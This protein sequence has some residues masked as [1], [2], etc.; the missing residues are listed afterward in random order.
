MAIYQAAEQ[1]YGVPWNVLAAINSVETDFGRNLAV[2]SAGAVGWMQFMPATW[3]R[4]GVDGN[5][6]GSKDPRKPEDAIPAAARLPEG[7]GPSHDLHDAI[8]AYNHAESYVQ[9]VLAL[10]RTLRP[11][12]LRHLDG[13]RSHDGPP[14]AVGMPNGGLSAGAARPGDRH[15]GR[16]PR[17]RALGN[18]QSDNAID[19]AVPAGNRGARR[20]RRHRGEYGRLAAVA[21]RRRDRRLQRHA[22]GRQGQ[23]G[24]LHAPDT[25]RSCEPG[26][27]VRAGPGDRLSGYANNVEHLHIGL[28]HGD[29]IA[30]GATGAAC[31]R[32]RSRGGCAAGALAARPS[33]TGP[34]R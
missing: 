7:V 32:Q 14:T 33:S 25:A 2:S 16:P 17:P 28:E 27:R 18:W 11:G 21:R 1:R 26:E 12:Q 13:L 3:A 15:A 29:P 20:R 24:L 10:A 30:S 23:R 8:F 31:G 34:S 4:Y 22:A 6:D 5:G 19:I 9:D